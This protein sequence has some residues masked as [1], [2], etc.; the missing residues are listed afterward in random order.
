MLIWLLEVGVYG[1]AE[2]NTV[3]A[4]GGARYYHYI[5]GGCPW[6]PVSAG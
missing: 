5:P 4:S 1:E 3:S 6:P 2:I